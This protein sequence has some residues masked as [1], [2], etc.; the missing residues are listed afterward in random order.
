MEDVEINGAVVTNNSEVPEKVPPFTTSQK[1]N[2]DITEK[3]QKLIDELH[4][5][6]QDAN[7]QSN[8]S[9]TT[10]REFYYMGIDSALSGVVGKLSSLLVEAIVND[11]Q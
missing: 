4:E 7:F 1:S 10:N 5:E 8:N 11:K 2:F 9:L 6:S 3:L